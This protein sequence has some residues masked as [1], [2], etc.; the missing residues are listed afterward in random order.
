VATY[1]IYYCDAKGKVFSVDDFE[2]T[3]DAGAIERARVRVN[4]RSAIFEVWERD[5]LIHRHTKLKELPVIGGK[6]PRIDRAI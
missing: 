5:R 1:R 6:P 4:G 2:A 3:D